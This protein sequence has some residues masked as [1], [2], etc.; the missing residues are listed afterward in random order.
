MVRAKFGDHAIAATVLPAC[1][2]A[3]WK[4]CRAASR[5]RARGRCPKSETSGVCR[6][7]LPSPRILPQQIARGSSRP[8]EVVSDCGVASGEATSGEHY[9]AVLPAEYMLNAGAS[10]QLRVDHKPAKRDDGLGRC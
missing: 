4:R 5:L 9:L 2:I 10:A 6:K 8:Y 7:P 1:S 3:R